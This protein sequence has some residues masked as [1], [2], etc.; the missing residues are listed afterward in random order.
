[1]TPEEAQRAQDMIAAME[2]QR[3]QALTQIVYL[4]AE[5]ASAKRK[6]AELEA[7]KEDAPMLPLPGQLLSNGHAEGVQA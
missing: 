5:L 2:A 3:N 6:I 7:K 1:M 4:Q